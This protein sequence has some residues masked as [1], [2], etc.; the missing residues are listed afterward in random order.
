MSGVNVIVISNLDD[1]IKSKEM[2]L[3]NDFTVVGFYYVF[4]INLCTQVETL[5]KLFETFLKLY[6]TI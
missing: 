4:E 5:S 1:F 3:S 6:T 2:I